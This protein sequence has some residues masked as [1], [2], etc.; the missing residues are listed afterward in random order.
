MALVIVPLTVTAELY[1]TGESVGGKIKL[2]GL[3][4]SGAITKVNVKDKAGQSVAYDL[5]LFRS[6]PT[7]A[8]ITNGAA[9]AISTD[10]AKCL[11]VIPVAG[12]SSGGTGGGMISTSNIYHP[13]ALDGSE[14]GWAALVVRGAPTYASVSDVTLEVMTEPL[15]R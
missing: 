8:T 6:E 14:D 13:F 11:G 12:L 15:S 9:F 2:V 7:A 1:A 3:G 5:F 4:N 10:L